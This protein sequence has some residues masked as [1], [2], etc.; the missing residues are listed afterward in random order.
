MNLV[1]VKP[2]EDRFLTL[3]GIRVHYVVAGQG[4]P[5]MLVHGLGSS[6]AAWWDNV[7]PLSQRH[8]VFAID[9]PGSGDSDKPRH[10]RYDAHEA[11]RFLHRFFQALGMPQVS[12]IGNSAGG[13]IS[14]IYACTYSKH[15]ER[16]VLVDSAGLG[17]PV[18]WFLRFT[19]I[20]LLSGLI[21][22]PHLRNPKTLLRRVFYRPRPISDLLTEELRRVRN[23]KGWHMA[24]LRSI[25]SGVSLLGLRKSVQILGD[26]KRLDKPL[27][28][29]WGREDRVIPVSH[30][31][32]AAKELPQAQVWVIPE[33]GH[34]PQMEKAQE[35][36]ERVL[37]FLADD[38]T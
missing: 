31:Y 7:G 4:S 19:S 35:F 38:G 6:V 5:V 2:W 12:L 33:C 32:R 24:V 3:D 1:D 23:H 16:L 15:V 30:A 29:V 14:A 34:W 17:R 11:A 20:P 9:L 37:K 13:L 18:A 22:L 25:Q 26:L 27:L 10:V 8:R 28:I 21:H 36:N